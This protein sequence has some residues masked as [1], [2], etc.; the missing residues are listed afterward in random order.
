MCSLIQ[1]RSTLRVMCRATRLRLENNVLLKAELQF[2][3]LL[4]Q[5]NLRQHRLHVG[6]YI[7]FLGRYLL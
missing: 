5:S 3:Q 4:Y 2:P 1:P 6:I 7:K